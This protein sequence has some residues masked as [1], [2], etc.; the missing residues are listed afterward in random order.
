VLV[1][2]LIAEW[3]SS[4]QKKTMVLQSKW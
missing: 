4:K 3:L 2:S 1:D